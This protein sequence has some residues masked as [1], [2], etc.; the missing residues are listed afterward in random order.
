MLIS[1]ENISLWLFFICLGMA[2][3]YRRD[4]KKV[5]YLLMLS[6]VSLIYFGLV[7]SLV[8]PSFSSQGQ[9]GGFLYS[10]LGDNAFG[11]I[12]TIIAHP[13]DSL[14]MLFT[15]HNNSPN[16]DYVKTELH[17]ILLASGLPL[18]LKK[19]Q[20]LL[21]LVPIYFQKLFHDNPLMWGIANQYNIEF[22]PIMA[23][24]IFK[25]ITEFKHRKLR[26]IMPFLV[27]VLVLA[28]TVR[29]M[30]KTVIFTDKS[31]I[32]VYK[33]SH[34]QRNYDVKRAH[35]LLLKIPADAKVSAQSPFVPHL[36]LRDAIYQ[37]PII[38][39]AEYIVY[40][41]K[42]SSYPMIEEEFILKISALE[43]SQ[44]WE[45]LYNDAVT[46]LKRTN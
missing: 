10:S 3:E 26:R 24:G 44:D 42:E 28:S 27:L 15:N 5:A 31:R 23:I 41:R 34:Y 19:P 17:L 9:Y 14:E 22:A 6:G 36:S 35:E 25:A 33:K 39:N 18:L 30:D 40:S 37:F 11:A 32:R 7:I 45:V 38:S 1:Q 29:T 21:M 8:I 2:I 43:Q 13:L 4:A 12:Q 20:Y 46:I 16:G